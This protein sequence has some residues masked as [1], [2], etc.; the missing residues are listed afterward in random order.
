MPTLLTVDDLLKKIEKKFRD[1]RLFVVEVL[2]YLPVHC[3]AECLDSVSER[4][5]EKLNQA[6]EVSKDA[7][8]GFLREIISFLFENELAEKIFSFLN[9]FPNFVPAKVP[10]KLLGMKG[11]KKAGKPKKE[12]KSLDAVINSGF[13]EEVGDWEADAH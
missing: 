2:K 6:K 9:S 11:W 7:R 4:L 5:R 13:S 8:D 12:L 10:Y 3:S 1:P